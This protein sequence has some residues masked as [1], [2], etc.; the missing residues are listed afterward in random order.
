MK[1]LDLTT[2]TKSHILSDYMNY[3]TIY[4][5][6]FY[7]NSKIILDSLLENKLFLVK[8]TLTCMFPAVILLRVQ[9]GNFA[10][11]SAKL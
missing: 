3:K 1:S 8:Q 2:H 11:P 9:Q 4:T 7:P 6:L 5:A 10:K